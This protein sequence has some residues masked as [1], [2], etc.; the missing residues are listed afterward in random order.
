MEYINR[1]FD[2]ESSRGHSIQKTLK[3]KERL[4]FSAL[5]FRFFIARCYYECNYDNRV[6]NY[7]GLGFRV[8]KTIRKRNDSGSA[9]KISRNR[10]NKF[11]FFVRRCFV[12]WNSATWKFCRPHEFSAT[13][14]LKNVDGRGTDIFLVVQG[15][16][17]FFMQ[18]FHTDRR[19]FY[20]HMKVK[21]K[22]RVTKNRKHFI[23]K[24][25]I[26][27]IQRI[28]IHNRDIGSIWILL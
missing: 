20:V 28:D 6:M 27:Y 2:E 26:K 12:F 18:I 13:V 23:L 14:K 21:L 1:E 25:Y 10:G 9:V 7:T 11:S 5:T 8:L 4:F 22:C 16:R 24:S 3:L 15:V 19:K 17:S